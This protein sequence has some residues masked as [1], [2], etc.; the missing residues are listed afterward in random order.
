VEKIAIVDG[1]DSL[2][3]E[4]EKDRC[5]D[6]DGILHRGFLV[7]VTG[8][9]GELLLAQRSMKK[10][11]WPGFWDGTVASHVGAGE[12]YVRASERRLVQELRL[13]AD[14]IEYLFKFRYHAKYRDIGSEKEICAVTLAGGVDF[15]AI[16]PVS[17]EITAVRTV[18]QE[19][20]IEDI[21]RNPGAY[22]PWL[23]LA[24][25][26]MNERGLAL[27]GSR[28]RAGATRT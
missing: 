24:M 27:P 7:M 9:D 12:D 18:T 5:H 8:G 15:Q 23:I 25:K 20:L 19:E 11:L 22:T 6:A 13:S 16:F 21:E 2:I 26:H 10:R 14:N 28:N 3:G 4:E 1:D 17:D